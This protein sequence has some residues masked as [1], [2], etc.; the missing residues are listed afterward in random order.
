MLETQLSHSLRSHMASEKAS[1]APS[2]WIVSQDDVESFRKSDTFAKILLYVNACANA[3][4]GSSRSQVGRLREAW[5]TTTGPEPSSVPEYARWL[6][7]VSNLFNE[8]N[9]VVEAIPL[10][11]MKNQRFGNKAFRDFH[12]WL[13]ENGRRLLRAVAL[14]LPRTANNAAA[15]SE[16]TEELF[17]YVK[18]SFGNSQRLDFG[19]GHE[20]H[21]FLFLVICL[22][23]VGV[24]SLD[25]MDQQS[26]LRASI[27]CIF[28]Q[29]VDFMRLIQLHYK[30]EPAGSHG[31][32][33]L[34]DYHHLSFIFGASQL[35]GA[36][37][38][39]D[40]NPTAILPKHITEENHVAAQRDEYLYF[41]NIG[42]IRD[43]KKGPF[44]EHSSILYNIS[45]IDEWSRIAGGLIRMFEAEVL[46]KYN[47]VQHLLFGAHL[48]SPTRTA[49]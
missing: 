34:D 38:V 44:H 30:L 16:L 39:T 47:V 6:L 5:T 35:A 20:L 40:A 36:D 7:P 1:G 23:E 49:A 45:G 24:M 10:H 3:C 12:A 42:W 41:S 28:W 15:A 26:L 14:A 22:E 27:L 21:F 46:S 2:K 33:G 48:P 4:K 32:W 13:D 31:V 43:N 8:L 25:E 37:A 9:R 18:D 11:D 19:T 29:Y 17:G